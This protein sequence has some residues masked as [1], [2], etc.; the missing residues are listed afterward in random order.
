MSTA[1]AAFWCIG[2]YR[3]RRSLRM[4]PTARAGLALASEDRPLVVIVPA[5]D[6]AGSISS[7]IETLR[8]QTHTSFR[9]VL[10]LD[11][12]TD[13]TEGV[14]RRAIDADPRFEI[15]TIDDCPDDWA[16]KVHAA[17]TGYTASAHARDAEHLLFTDADCTFHPE[18]LR[19]TAALLE[20]RDLDLLSLF[21]TLTTDSWFE[22]LV[23][24]AASFELGRWFPLNRANAD[25]GLPKRP[26]ANGQFM[27]FRGAAYRELGGH[28]HPEV[29]AALLEDIAFAQRFGRERRRTGLMLAD[30]IVRCRMYDN[31][32]Q[33]RKGWKRIYTES[34]N[35]KPA[36]L[37]A[38]AWQLRLLAI[39]SLAALAT[40]ALALTAL[41]ALTELDV[42]ALSVSGLAL[43]AWTGSLRLI[44]RAAHAP[45]WLIP[46]WPLGQWLVAGILTD[47]ARDL[48]TGVPT[49]WGGRSYTRQP[50]R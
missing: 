37:R 26:F 22:H 19:A 50:R 31:W 33:F 13:D 15:V 38:A 1:F 27:L 2:C 6:E 24:P 25:A 28:Q 35:R 39:G 41:P 49:S 17:H 14:A 4:I 7:L 8:A 36:R 20:Q 3:I 11:R 42:Y 43:I 40:L 16:G 48:S 5:H 46:V 44:H 30:A 12:C 47:A 23:Q 9:V 18:A 21:S 32:A 34:A 10:A 45:R 29:R